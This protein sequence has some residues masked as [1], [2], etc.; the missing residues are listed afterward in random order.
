[1][2]APPVGLLLL[3]VIFNSTPIELRYLAFA[4]PFPG[5]LLA[6]ALASLPH[7]GASAWAARCSRS[8]PSRCWR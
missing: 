2:L 8:R 4:T 7:R 5:L 3:D 1:V 6:G